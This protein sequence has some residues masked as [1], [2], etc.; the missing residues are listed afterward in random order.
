MTASV[1]LQRAAFRKYG[2]RL[3]LPSGKPR[4]AEVVHDRQKQLSPSEAEE[5]DKQGTLDSAR[6]YYIMSL[7][8]IHILSRA[9][10][11]GVVGAMSKLTTKHVV[12]RLQL[13]GGSMRDCSLSPNGDDLSVFANEWSE[14]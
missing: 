9:S 5:M 10:G 3:L 13:D 8:D 1:E 7:A 12:Y 4:E 14:L 2:K 6:D 11:F